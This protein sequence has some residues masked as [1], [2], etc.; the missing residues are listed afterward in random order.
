MLYL[1][2]GKKNYY[3]DRMG[4]VTRPTSKNIR[5]V[6]KSA[7]GTNADVSGKSRLYLLPRS[8]M[9][10][11]SEEGFAFAFHF[12]HGAPHASNNFI[13]KNSTPT[14]RQTHKYI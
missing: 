3:W 12:S 11:A 1:C 4:I 2:A 6:G 8:M 7:V 9:S 10:E 5:G 14:D 13:F